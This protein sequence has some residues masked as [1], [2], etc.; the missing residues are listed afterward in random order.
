MKIPILVIIALFSQTSAHAAPAAAEN[1]LDA[2]RAAF[3]QLKFGMFIHF[4]M[5][6]YQEKEWGDPRQDPASFH[7]A[8]LDCGQWADAA[9]SAGMKY[10][11]LTTKHHDGFSLWVA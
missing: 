8:K 1:S 9:R 10:A 2:P 6:T 11:V 4:N 5:G 3:L 7:P